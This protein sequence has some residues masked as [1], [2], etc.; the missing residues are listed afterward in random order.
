MNIKR[1]FILF[2][3]VSLL[4]LGLWLPANAA[5]DRQQISTPTAGP[6]GRIVYV[7]QAGDS[8][9]RVAALNNISEQQLR[10]L[11]STLDENCSLV[12]G[13]ELLIGIISLAGTPTAGPSPTPVPPTASPTPFT[14]T[15]EV[16]ILLFDDANGNALRETTEPAIAGG[17]VSLTENNGEYSAAQN[18]VIP[19]DPAAYQ[20]VCFLDVPEGNYNITVGIPD[21][22]NPT[23][24]LNYSLDV[25]AGD[26]ASVDFGAQSKDVVVDPGANDSTE[27]SG[28]SPLFGIIGAVLLLGG[29]VLG[30]F[31]WRS[32]KPESKLSGGNNILKK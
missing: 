23:M 21:N 18:T 26:R 25:N 22:Y 28:T 32:G 15:T 24:N 19:A 27:N 2:T 17:A 6:D 7:V 16:C 12:E 13:Q 4:L 30:Y 29:A 10:T 11:N 20:G 31:A 9:I 14:G 8:C 3:L 1:F 5:P